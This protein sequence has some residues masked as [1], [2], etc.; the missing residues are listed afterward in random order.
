MSK[1]VTKDKVRTKLLE[2]CALAKGRPL[3]QEEIREFVQDLVGLPVD[4]Q[5]IRDAIEWAMGEAFVRYEDNTRSEEREWI[6]TQAGQA[7]ARIR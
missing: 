2:V 7:E 4:V 5:Q 1:L 6:I 3:S